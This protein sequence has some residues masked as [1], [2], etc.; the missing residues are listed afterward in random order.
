MNDIEQIKITGSGSAL[1]GVG[2]LADG[3]AVF[4]PGALPGE[5]VRIE[6]VREEKRYCVAELLEVLSPSPDRRAPDC[7]L[8]GQCGGCQGRH[9][10]YAATLEMKRRRVEDA[11]QRIGGVP[12]PDVRPVLGCDDPLA[13]R[14]K[15]EFAVQHGRLCVTR[16]ESHALMPVDRCALMHPA[17]NDMLAL[18]NDMLPRTDAAHIKQVVL[19]A[20]RSGDGMLILCA[21]APVTEQARALA[22]SAMAALP[23]IKSAWLIR[24]AHHAKH[25][26]DGTAI[27]LAG[28]RTISETL[29]GLSFEISPQSFFQVNPLQAERLY[30]AALRPLPHGGRVLDAYCGTG[31]ITLAAA[32]RGFQ[33]LGIEIVAPAVEDARRNAARND[34]ARMASFMCA[35]A[36]KAVPRLV[37]SGTKFDAAIL[38]P[39][40]K[41]AD[42]KLLRALIAAEIG[43]ISYV[44]C[45][46][47]TLAR[48]MK[49]LRDEGGY[50][51]EWAQPVDMFPWT[52]HVETVCLLTHK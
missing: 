32:R 51:L 31:T 2:H 13:L 5:H 17:I 44:S 50:A 33:A 4:V 16:A 37:S 43:A 48:D 28:H 47:A 6:I 35:D 36:A 29:L 42:P 52:G 9:M 25:A 26:V 11:L 49:L 38:D 21:D 8:Y 10:T 39:P 34:L 23:L 41:G 20:S 3:R 7:P 19:R 40:R 27:H 45:D 30:T 1:Q 12:S 15:A 46:P 22:V 18:L 24:Q 14:N